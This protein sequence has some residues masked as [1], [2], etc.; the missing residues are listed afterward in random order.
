[1]A[2]RLRYWLPVTAAFLVLFVGLF[3]SERL[4]LY[5][6]IAGFDKVMHVAGGLVAVWILDYVFYEEIK[7]LV[8]LKILLLLVGGACLVG[9]FWE[10]A[11]FAA[12]FTRQSAPWLYHWFHG[13]DLNDTIGDLASDL[14]GAM[15]FAVPLALR[16]R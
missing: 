13:G 11:E 8:P 7:H 10:F 16:H 14:L 3:V 6:R 12:N 2:E 9:V 4:L 5:D 1:M 15:L